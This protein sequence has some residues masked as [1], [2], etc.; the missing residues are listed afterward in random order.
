MDRGS[1]DDD[2]DSSDSPSSSSSSDSDGEQ[3]S[4]T[5]HGGK[6]AHIDSIVFVNCKRPLLKKISCVVDGLTVNV[7]VN[8][9]PAVCFSA[10]FQTVA[11]EVDRRQLLKRAAVLVQVCG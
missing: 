7:T 3:T 2:D 1:S 10:V 9:V 11:T 6:S 5:R 8:N 4:P